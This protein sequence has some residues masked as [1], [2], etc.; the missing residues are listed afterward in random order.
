MAFAGIQASTHGGGEQR[1]CKRCEKVFTEAT[2]P[3]G[4]PVFCYS[5]NIPAGKGEGSADHDQPVINKSHRGRHGGLDI[6]AWASEDSPSAAKLPSPEKDTL[7]G[8]EGDID[9][10]LAAVEAR[11]AAL[12]KK[13]GLPA[14]MSILHD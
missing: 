7:F 14:A 9:K 12:R 1:W 4:H 5:K 13:K 10:E 2:C 8:D 3:G 6:A 11:L